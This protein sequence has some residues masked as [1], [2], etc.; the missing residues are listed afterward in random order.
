M[1]TDVIVAVIY[2]SSVGT[3]PD[4]FPESLLALI[5]RQYGRGPVRGHRKVTA[6]GTEPAAVLQRTVTAAFRRAF[7][8]VF[9]FEIGQVSERGD[10]FASASCQP[11]QQV[12]I[13]AGLLH[14]Q[15][16]GQVAS[17]PVAPHEA[18][19]N[20]E[21]A[22]VF[23][24]LNGDHP[25][26]FPVRNSLFQRPEKRTVAQHVAHCHMSAGP[27]RGFLDLQSLFRIRRDGLFQQQVIAFFHR[28]NGFPE[29]IA[30]HRRDDGGIPQLRLCQQGFPV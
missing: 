8:S 11:Y 5:F 30:V 16:A 18:V 12:H 14:H 9:R 3:G 17:S 15:R 13:M 24:M 29:M 6:V 4:S 23:I 26:D 1:I 10:A 7:G 27:H 21:V 28:R 2:A 22:D 20:M 25:A 19:C